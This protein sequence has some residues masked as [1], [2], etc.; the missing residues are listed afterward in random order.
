MRVLARVVSVRLHMCAC[1]SVCA[2]ECVCLS[3]GVYVAFARS[4]AGCLGCEAARDGV[5]VAFFF[6]V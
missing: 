4:A 3:F 5:A 6:V 1:V 2:C